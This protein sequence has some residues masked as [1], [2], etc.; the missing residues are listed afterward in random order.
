[1]TRNEKLIPKLGITRRQAQYLEWI[2]TYIAQNDGESPSLQEIGA[3]MGTATSAARGVVDALVGR[4]H[5]IKG[6]K[7]SPRSIAL[8]GVKS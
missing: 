6:D 8:P 1:M 5:L 4:G 2:K 7:N 3:A